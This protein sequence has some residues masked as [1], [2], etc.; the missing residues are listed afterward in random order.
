MFF[1]GVVLFFFSAQKKFKKKENWTTSPSLRQVF[2]GGGAGRW[3]PK[4]LLKH[5]LGSFLETSQ[6]ISFVLSF[7]VRLGKSQTLYLDLGFQRANNPAVLTQAGLTTSMF[8]GSVAHVG[9]PCVPLL[10]HLCSACAEQS[11]LAWAGGARCLQTSAL[12]IVREQL[13]SVQLSCL[14][15][16]GIIGL[17]KKKK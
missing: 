11:L 6:F 1:C 5:I 15:I 17:K 4:E 9:Q 10:P 7:L 3:V 2:T 12:L 8:V 13:L 16:R 14:E